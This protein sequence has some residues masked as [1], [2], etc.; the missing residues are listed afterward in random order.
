MYQK[1]LIPNYFTAQWFLINF[2]L[3]ILYVVSGKLGIEYTYYHGASL[4]W[5]PSGI[6]VAAVFIF[7]LKVWP[8]IFMGTFTLGI[9]LFANLNIGLF[10]QLLGSI[11]CSFF[12]TLEAVFAYIAVVLLTNNKHPLKTFNHVIIFVAFA[13]IL[14]PL[15]SALPGSLVYIYYQD[16]WQSFFNRFFNWWLGDMGGILLITPLLINWNKVEILLFKPAKLIEFIL[17]IILLFIIISVFFTGT[18]HFPKAII[19]PY[20]I[21]FMFRFGRFETALMIL[22]LAMILLFQMNNPQN[23]FVRDMPD[24]PLIPF[25]FLLVLFSVTSLLIVAIITEYKQ[26]KQE[27][28]DKN[29]ELNR[30][31]Q[32]T[33]NREERTIELKNEINELLIKLGLPKK[34][35]S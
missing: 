14:A 13:A 29:E 4:I 32:L 31:L 1:H 28:T 12:N 8:A 15:I 20:F 26:T 5:I 17:L 34:Y 30:W 16:D 22:F 9:P 7:G 3:F 18:Y 35:L 33:L 2:S 24:Y 10:N 27:L 19:F 23:L 6:A 25:V 11:A 21:L